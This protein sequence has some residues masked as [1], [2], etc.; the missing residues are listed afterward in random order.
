MNRREVIGATRLPKR[1]LVVAHGSSK[2]RQKGVSAQTLTPTATCGPGWMS[3]NQI[4]GQGTVGFKFRVARS[5]RE[6]SLL[7]AISTLCRTE[8]RLTGRLGW[9]RRSRL[10]TC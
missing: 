8:V 4:R 6:Q 3:E 10:L 5:A 2:P 7:G 9:C 1:T